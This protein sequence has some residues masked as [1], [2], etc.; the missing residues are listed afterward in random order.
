VEDLADTRL[1]PKI[2]QLPGVGL[3]SISGGQK[4][5]VRI[6]ANPTALAARGLNMEDL[7]SALIAAN[8][9]QAKGNF[10]GPHQSYQIGANDQLM[11]SADYQ[12]LVIAYRNGAP[13]KL[14][15]VA[16]VVDD[17]ENVRQA[18]WMN[19]TPAV[20]L[21]IQRQPGANIIT[22]VDR[23]KKLLPQLT[24]TLPSSV[25]V[26]ILT[27][28]TTT[29][30]ASVKDVQ[31]SLLLT[32]ALVVMV[33]FLF[34]RNL[35]ATLIPSVAVPLSLI[36]TFAVMY[37]LGYSLNNLTLMALTIS[38]GFVVDDAIVMIENIVRYIE[39][40]ETP[41]RGGAERRLADRIHDRVADHLADRGADPAAVH[42]R[43]RGA[44]VPGIRG[45]AGRSRFWS[46]RW[47]R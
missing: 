19:A 39:Q 20:I 21:N 5:A 47:S 44:A 35:S 8:V 34:L 27:D 32:V 14:A 2:S 31:F 13:V 17:V 42:G 10:D 46:R 38:T 24:L 12:P 23:I 6:Q 45:D 41:M 3:V 37:L 16:D 36:G 28:R 4:P 15:E 40:G 25:D 1:A 30:R 22:V 11:S 18:A 26:R 43:Y 9:N 29:I 7:R 33:I